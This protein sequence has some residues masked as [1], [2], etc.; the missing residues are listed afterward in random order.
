MLFQEWN[1]AFTLAEKYPEYR[2]QVGFFFFFTKRCVYVLLKYITSIFDPYP[3][4]TLS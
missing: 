2:E 1:E 4:N 3:M